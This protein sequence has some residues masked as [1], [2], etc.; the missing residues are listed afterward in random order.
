MRYAWDLMHEYLKEAKLDRGI[1]GF[2]T[3][4]ALHYLRGW[5]VYS[6]TRVDHFIANSRFVAS[7]IEKFYGRKAALIHPPVDLSF[8]EL[9]EKKDNYYIT[10]SRFVPYKKIDLI[11]AAFN[12]MPEKKL[13]VLGDG[14]EWK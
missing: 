3:Q 8:Y 10:A 13:V 4:L 2:L 5:D 9:E 11:V 1:K 7:R 12:R 6:S 14:P